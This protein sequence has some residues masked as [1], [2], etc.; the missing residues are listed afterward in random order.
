MLP[1]LLKI[2]K[3][4]GANAEFKVGRDGTTHSTHRGC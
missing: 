4:M 1:A 3:M 2:S